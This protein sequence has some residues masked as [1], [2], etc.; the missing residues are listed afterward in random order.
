MTFKG[1]AVASRAKEQQSI[2]VK[3]FY[4]NTSYGL[5]YKK[6]YISKLCSKMMI[7]GKT[8]A[9]KASAYRMLSF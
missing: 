8:R 1:E 5:E 2:C 4:S 3:H 7:Y 6:I 9:G